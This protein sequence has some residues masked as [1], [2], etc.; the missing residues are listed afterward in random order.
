MRKYIF[1][2][3]PILVM[4]CSTTSTNN[5]YYGFDNNPTERESEDLDDANWSNPMATNTNNNN[6]VVRNDNVDNSQYN[7][8]VYVPVIVPWWNSYH[9]W[10]SVPRRRSGVYV[11]YSN[12]WGPEW[13]SPWYSYH[14]YHGVTWYDYWYV[15]PHY[16]H[17]HSQPVYSY[18]DRPIRRSEGRSYG[19]SRGTYS[20][21]N[22]RGT[23]S[24]NR[25]SSRN[26]NP[27]SERYT[28]SGTNI[29]R[30][31]DNEDSRS[32]NVRRTSSSSRS[33]SYS[34]P[35][36]STRSTGTTR[37]SG[38]TNSSGN[39][40]GNSNVR[41]TPSSSPAPSTKPSSN[42]SGSSKSSGSR[43]SGSSRGGSSRSSGSSR[44]K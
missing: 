14:P 39:S 31:G 7:G 18:N 21:Y 34:T 17:W 5:S 20:V 40:R 12:Y 26:Y 42:S 6:D 2:L 43:S 16:R 41:D 24:N 9:G 1:L 19:S 8:P 27:R 38:S 36:G 10:G 13:Y 32:G 33:N 30:R 29:Y 22:P 28:A 25:S 11:H 4:S 37:S 3:L 15:N 44:G 23:N 35:S